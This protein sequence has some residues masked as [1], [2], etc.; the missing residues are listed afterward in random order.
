MEAPPPTGSALVP[1][2]RRPLVNAAPE[3]PRVLMIANSAA[4]ALVPRE[5]SSARSR[6]RAQDNLPSYR[7]KVAEQLLP[8]IAGPD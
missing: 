6:H 8:L 7:L 4:C 1:L 5:V 2:P 3:T